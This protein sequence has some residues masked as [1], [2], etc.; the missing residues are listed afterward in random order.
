MKHIV[1]IFALLLLMSCGEQKISV[2]EKGKCIEAIKEKQI[3]KM[4]QR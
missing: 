2:E 1:I 3:S 4:V